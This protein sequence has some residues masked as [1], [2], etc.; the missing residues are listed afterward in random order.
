MQQP[1]PLE[2]DL[3]DTPAPRLVA[4]VRCG[5][6]RNRRI[7]PMSA[8]GIF[9]PP[10]PTNEP[11]KEYAPGSPER[12]QLRR[13]LDQM[14]SERIELPLVIGGEDV[15]TGTTA[16][17]VMPHKKSHVLADAHQGGQAE[18]DKAIRAAAEAWE[19]WSRLAL[20]GACRRLPP[21]SRAPVRPVACDAQRRDDA[22]PVEDRAPGRDRRRL[23][24]D[25]LL[26]LQRRVHDADLRAAAGLEPGRVEP[27]GVPAARG[28]RLRRLAVQLHRD[29]REPAGER[30]ADGE[31]GR[32]GSRPEPRPTPRTS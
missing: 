31:H 15:T 28:L 11:V 18:V 7:K 10:A 25:R 26:P 20:G 24:G 2:P 6:G 12:E 32:S 19:D 1:V 4:D 14:Q 8:P 29:R 27:D 5:H 21:R 30:G 22:R 17:I 16:E 23:R 3:P 9:R 13:R